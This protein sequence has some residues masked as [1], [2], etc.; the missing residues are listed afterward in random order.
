MLRVRILTEDFCIGLRRYN[1]GDIINTAKPIADYMIVNGTGEVVVD[2]KDEVVNKTEVVD[3][4]EKPKAKPKPKP[5]KK[6][7][8]RRDMKAV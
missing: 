7:Y 1:K 5:R 3:V 4:T 2:S 8:N 6:T